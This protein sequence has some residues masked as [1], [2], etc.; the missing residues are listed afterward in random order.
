MIKLIIAFVVGL[1]IGALIGITLIA[2]LMANRGRDDD[3]T[4]GD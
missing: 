1:F 2:L 3:S 4:R